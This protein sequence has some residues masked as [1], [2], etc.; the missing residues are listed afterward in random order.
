MNGH[1]G[2]EAFM[3]VYYLFPFFFFF[4]GWVVGLGEMEWCHTYCFF[5]FL[6]Y[7]LGLGI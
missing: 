3:K 2:D 5:V 6:S 7:S 4:F 1:H